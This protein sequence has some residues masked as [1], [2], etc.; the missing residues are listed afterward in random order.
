MVEHAAVNRGVEGSSPSSGAIFSNEIKGF[1][2][3]RTNR[4]QILAGLERPQVRFPKTIRFRR[5][6][7]TIYGKTKKYDFYRLVYYVAGKR[8]TRSFKGYAEAKTEAEQKVREIA[9]GSQAAALTGEQSRDALAALEPLET[10]RQSTGKRLSLLGVVSEHVEALEK[11]RGRTVG[12]AVEGY[13]QTVVTVARKDVTEAVTEFVEGRKHKGEAKDG[14]RSQLSRHYL[15]I[16]SGWLRKFARTFPATALCDLTKEHL[17]LYFKPLTEFGTKNRNDRRAALKM[18]FA[19]AM[20]QDYLPRN[21]RL[22]EAD[23]MAREVVEAV[24]TDFYRPDELQK[25]LN[26]A[27]ENIRP[28][29][30][31]GGLAGLRGEEIMRLEWADVWR[32]EGHIELSARIAKTRQ[33]R[34]VEICPALAAWLEPYRK[35][36]GK[37]RPNKVSHYSVEFRDLRAS[38]K[39]PT[40]DNGLRHAFCTYHFALQANEGLTAQQAGNSPA[41]IHAHYKGLATKA[42]AEKWFAVMPQK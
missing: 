33:R 41:M 39:I 16:V 24:P 15:C 8:V 30:A 12:E 28:I 36:T 4:A 10:F 34:L 37:I 1:D 19:W 21:H 20:R 27:P 32:V 5:I 9:D 31:L 3:Y 14:Q 2:T 22:C 17:A 7:A 38:L 6:E 42:D 35:A 23:C 18:F 13:L 25:L 29:I 40:R 26:N 11:L